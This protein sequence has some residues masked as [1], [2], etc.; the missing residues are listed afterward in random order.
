MRIIPHGGVFK[1]YMSEP[2][3]SIYLL[4]KNGADTIKETI[5]SVIAQTY[6]NWELLIMDN[7]S[8]DGT[9]DIINAFSDTR[10][11][12]IQN[13]KDF[14]TAYNHYRIIFGNFLH[15]EYI[16]SIDDDSIL[17]PE[18][19]KKEVDILLSNNNIV[20]V[21]CDTK[22]LSSTGETLFNAKIP[23]KKNIVTRNEYINYTL[24]TARGS[25][26][27]GH[28]RLTRLNVW[29]FAHDELLIRGLG[30][31]LINIYSTYFY[32]PAIVLEKGDMYIIHETLSAGRMERN[33]HS[34]KYNQAKLMMSWLELLRND[35]ETKI[36]PFLFLFAR[37]MIIFR[38]FARRIAWFLFAR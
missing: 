31:G 28:Q 23:F 17:Y 12:L 25:I 9:I 13:E 10:I 34:F 36:S 38:S 32:F 2:L 29:R 5:E 35:K 22:Y 20:F 37:F 30:R 3:V 4:V 11:H 8:T 6:Q 15:G 1:D 19:I 7:C 27:E 16:K 14:G 24:K 21:T 18:C 33:S 26:Q